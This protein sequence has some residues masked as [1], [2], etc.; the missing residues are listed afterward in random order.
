M[1][2][3]SGANSSRCGCVCERER[4]REREK[5]GCLFQSAPPRENLSLSEVIL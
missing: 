1:F 3:E 2:K 4:E 5:D